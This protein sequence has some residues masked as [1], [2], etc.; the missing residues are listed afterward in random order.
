MS[1]TKEGHL[2]REMGISDVVTNV[3]S[4]SIGSG[5][6]LLPALVYVIL[7]H[8]S[9]LAYIFCGLIFLSI[10]LCF[11]ELSN[12]IPETGGLYTYIDR[13][14]GPMA[15]F[16]ATM[17]YVFGIGVLV[18]AALLNA[19][20]DILSTQNEI[21]K[22]PYIRFL[23]FAIVLGL[24]SFLS[25]RGMKDSMVLIKILTWTKVLAIVSLIVFGISK[26]EIANIAWEGFPSF[27]KIGEGSILLIFAFMGGEFALSTGGEMKDPKRTGPLGFLFGIIGA[28]LIF[29]LI[30]LVTQGVLGDRRLENQEAP[31]AEL[32][33][34]LFGSLGFAI[35][36]IVTFIAVWST[37]SSIF[38]LKNRVLYAAS[39]DEVIPKFF[40]RLHPKYQ[41]PIVAI[42][43]LGILDLMVAMSG[44]FQY[45][46]ILVTAGMLVIYLGGLFAFLKFRLLAKSTDPVSFKVPAGY[47]V[48]IFG[49][50]AMVWVFI[51]ISQEEMLAIGS[52]LA[53]VIVLYYILNYFKIINKKEI[54]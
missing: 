13:A 7:G 23:F 25:I 14:F 27:S 20:I 26:I 17:L 50:V 8:G 1:E 10:G 5:I 38:I 24:I 22:E 36:L 11:G 49:I 3:L 48:A 45:L 35:L 34:N 12:R 54:V 28:I 46:L 2:K 51:Q 42:L 18:S 40:S 31:L 52:F 9:I 32:A 43:F 41:T 29:C 16:V 33:Q 44:S 6:F 53:I 19:M 4:I 37:F 39:K 21:F 30:H 15:G 47:L